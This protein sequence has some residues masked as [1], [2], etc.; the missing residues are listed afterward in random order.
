[1]SSDV[2]K[3]ALSVAAVIVGLWVASSI[4][5]PIASLKK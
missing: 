2:T 1:M 5:N 3:F 4:P